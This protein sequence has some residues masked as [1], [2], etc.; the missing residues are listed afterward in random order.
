MADGR[1]WHIAERPRAFKL[2]QLLRADQ[3]VRATP[4]A[5]RGWPAGLT[6]C[7]NRSAVAQ[8]CRCQAICRCRE[9]PITV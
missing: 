5:F 7:R 6:E 9:F 2:Q 3:S 4:V 8:S 1:S